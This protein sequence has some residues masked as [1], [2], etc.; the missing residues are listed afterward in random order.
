MKKILPLIFGFAVLMYFCLVFV[1]FSFNPM[2]WY[3]FGRLIA[4]AFILA[5]IVWVI[6]S[7]DT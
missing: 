5:F 4:I 7:K 3:W 6:D 1:F 2:E